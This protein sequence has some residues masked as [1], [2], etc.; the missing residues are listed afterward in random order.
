MN[1]IKIPYNDLPED[2]KE[3]I[4]KEI[5]YIN[6]NQ[7]PENLY[8]SIVQSSGTTGSLA[9]IFELPFGLVMK[10]RDLNDLI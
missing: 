9:K 3:Q 1:K 7:N 2:L 8:N 4:Q 6:D 5:D 10:I